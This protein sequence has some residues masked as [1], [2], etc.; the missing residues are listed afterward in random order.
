MNGN[1]LEDG[2]EQTVPI[3]TTTIASTE[4]PMDVGV[5]VFTDVMSGSS[6]YEFIT[7]LFSL[8]YIPIDIVF[9]LKVSLF[10]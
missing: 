10:L 1:H 2:V 3:M 6:L 8:K 7:S 4:S 9:A 5:P